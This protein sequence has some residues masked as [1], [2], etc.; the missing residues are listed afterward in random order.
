MLL[1]ALCLP[2]S[3]CSLP[4]FLT[5][6]CPKPP[7]LEL[8]RLEIPDGGGRDTTVA[9]APLTGSLAIAP[10]ITP[11][12]YGRRNIV[13]RIEDSQYGTY[14]SREWAIPLA[15]QLGLL[16]ER[17]IERQP[18]TTERAVFDPPSRRSQ[19]YIWRGS[20]RQFD[21]VDRGRDVFVAVE[22]EAQ[23]IRTSDDSVLWTGS[24]KRERPVPDPT[25]PA[26]IRT[27]SQLADETVAELA[28]DARL[29]LART[30]ASTARA[31]SD[32]KP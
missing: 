32:G 5:G 26:I 20:V 22:L 2:L 11:G 27:L 15:D 12:L 8:Y 17:V 7:A 18:L 16:S 25:M 1:L 29:A 24:A 3:A 30:G 4:C 13:F 9:G 19:T 21:E 14:P 28:A 6:R 10:Y 31:E 23:L